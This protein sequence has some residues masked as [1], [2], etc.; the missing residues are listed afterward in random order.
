[1]PRK[2]MIDPGIWRSEQVNDLSRNARLLFIGMFSNADDAGRL[3]G[4]SR[5]L[6]ANIFP[7]DDDVTSAVVGEWRDEILRA[8]LAVLYETHGREYLYLPT[9]A[10]HQKIDRPSESTLPSPDEHS[11]NIRRALDE[12]SS[13][14]EE[15]RIEENRREEEASDDATPSTD[16]ESS[17]SDSLPEMTP[18][19]EELQELA[20]WGR[21]TMSDRAWLEDV[22]ADYPSAL[23]RDVRDM[24]DYWYGRAEQDKKV[25]H[26]KGQWKQRFRTWLRRKGDFGGGNGNK[27][28]VPGNQPGGAFEQYEAQFKN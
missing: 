22:L 20:S 19:E 17:D 2:R 24:R 11:S 25:K 9:W 7:Y 4:S 10:R 28:G 13:L 26:S 27:R 16:I 6:R 1:M 14:I 15:N 18:L 5:F 12:H 3:H 8:G 23:P 21:F